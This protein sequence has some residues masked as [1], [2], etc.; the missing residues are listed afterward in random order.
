[1]NKMKR[2]NRAVLDVKRSGM[3]LMERALLMMSDKSMMM[4][5]GVWISVIGFC[6]LIWLPTRYLPYHWDSAGYVI[7]TAKSILDSNFLKLVSGFSDFAHPPLIPLQ[8]AIGWKIFGETKL[9]THLLMWPYLPMLM[10][11]TYYVFKKLISPLS[12]IVV[13]FL[14]GF[15]P[16]V[17]A[18]Y[19]IAYVDLP[20]AALI[21]TA[22]ALRI[23]K[24]KAWYLAALAMAL[25]TKTSALLLLPLFVFWDYKDKRIG[26]K[27]NI[28]LI[29]WPM[30]LTL[31]WYAYHFLETGWWF[32]RPNRGFPM[33]SNVEELMGPLKLTGKLFF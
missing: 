21:M 2:K 16:V 25:M 6:G 17:L 7:Q 23:S 20:M 19:V 13:A 11:S 9:I 26:L 27:K 12:G 32:T 24:P 28:S 14:V 15:S 1:M 30:M 29:I 8:L 10:I 18:E 31:I 33:P 5:L 3:G 4:D 22:L